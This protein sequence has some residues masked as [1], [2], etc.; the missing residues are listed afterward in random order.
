MN[1]P[2]YKARS[3][4]KSCKNCNNLAEII[5]STGFACEYWCCSIKEN[6]ACYHIDS[7]LPTEPLGT[8]RWWNLIEELQN[9]SIIN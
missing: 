8:L 9:E 7:S 3:E 6:W 2:I 5:G 4:E 1:H